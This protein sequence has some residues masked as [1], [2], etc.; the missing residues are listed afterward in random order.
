MEDL[1]A[2]ADEHGVLSHD[3]ARRAGLEPRQL[4]RLA[5]RGELILLA[6]GWYAIGPATSAATTHALLTRAMLRSHPK[7]AV[8]GHHSALQL[9]GLPTYHPDWSRARLHRTTPGSPR[10]RD[11]LS[12]GRMI[13]PDLVAAPPAGRDSPV[14]VIPAL[15]VVQ[16]GF[17]SH[18]MASLVAADAAVRR[19]LITTAELGDVVKALSMHPGIGPVRTALGHVDGRRESPGETR[20]GHSFQLM[21]IPVTPQF[22]VREPGFLAFI[23]FVVDG[24]WVAVEFDGRIKYGRALD[25]DDA[26]GPQP[27]PEER[28]WR[29]KR[30]E[31]RLGEIGFEVIRVVWSDLDDLDTLGRR[32]RAAVERSQLRH[33]M[34]TPAGG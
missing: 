29:E 10:T 28:L 32:V 6:R 18:P 11:G 8:A 16:V 25:P 3:D 12:L 19:S 14:T 17:S 1:A 9:L 26:R 31:D 20:L 34:T 27:S 21:S 24:T 15:A 33:G 5:S 23:D 13:S 4:A 2:V 30:R 7:R 22:E